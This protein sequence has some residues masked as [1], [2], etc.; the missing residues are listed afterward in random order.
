MEGVH[1]V[2]FLMVEQFLRWQQAEIDGG[3]RSAPLSE[4]EAA[5]DAL[6]YLD[7]QRHRAGFT[8]AEAVR[9]SWK[10]LKTV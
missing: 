6:A 4:I 1:K 10:R 5:R 7:A 8:T 9:R 2:R 3:R